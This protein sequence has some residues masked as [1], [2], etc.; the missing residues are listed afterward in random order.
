MEH[1]NYNLPAVAGEIRYNVS[2]SKYSFFGAG[3]SADVLFM[4]SDADDLVS[5]LR[6]KPKDLPVTVIGACSN[7][8]IRDGGV[9][10]VVIKLGTWFDNIF[11]KD[12]ILEVGSANSLPK[13]ANKAADNGLA[14][15]EFLSG[16]PGLIGGALVMN[17]GCYGSCIAEVFVEAEAVDYDGHV[18]WLNKENVTFE[19]RHTSLK[20]LII[21]RIWLKCEKSDTS[22]VAKKMNEL[23]MKRKSAQAVLYKSCGSAFKNPEGDRKAWQLIDQAG[24]RGLKVG[25]A[26]VSDTHCN[27][28]VNTGKATATELEE[29]GEEVRRRVKNAFG[30]ELQWEIIRIGDPL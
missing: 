30:I 6:E 2:L 23:L 17:A 14:G 7:L 24:C 13:L 9:R 1:L 20:D 28:I 18:H 8:L 16:I 26:M 10:G 5:F 27:F 4:P 11:I 19:Y 29:L 25:D 15:L 22:T 21:T 3:G 12:D